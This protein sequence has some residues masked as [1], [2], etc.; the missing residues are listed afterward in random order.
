[1]K[2]DSLIVPCSLTRRTRRM[3][4][5]AG[6]IGLATVSVYAA[7]DLGKA[8]DLWSQS[9]AL[10]A[11]ADYKGAIAKMTD[12]TRSGADNYLASL[13]TGWLALQ[14]KDYDLA[15]ANYRAAAGRAPA[16]V[17]PAQGLAS[18]YRAKGD[19][20]NAEHACRQILSHDPGNVTALQMLGAIYFEKKDYSNAAL[21]YDSILRLYPEDTT[22]LSSYGWAQI[23]LNHK[24]NAIPEFQRLLILSP[25]Y[26]DAEAGY[27][28]ATTP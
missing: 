4:L 1:M 28:A 15:I 13:R 2:L 16:A 27:T 25:T 24:A 21:V 11:K 19:N 10:E 14:N 20:D 26:Q 12:L 7:V 8:G 23:Y 3:S 9:V 6:L 18:A 17:T 22:A 5:L